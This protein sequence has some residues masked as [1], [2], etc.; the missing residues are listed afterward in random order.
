MKLL[1]AIASL[2]LFIVSCKKD[3][4]GCTD[5]NA[6]NHNPDA[7]INDGSCLYKGPATEEEEPLEPEPTYSCEDNT[8]ICRWH[9]DS[10]YYAHIVSDYKVEDRWFYPS[11]YMRLHADSSYIM[12]VGNALTLSGTFSFINSWS[13]VGILNLSECHLVDTLGFNG[14]LVLVDE[15]T[16]PNMRIMS[17][18]ECPNP[19][20]QGN[21]ERCYTGWIYHY[22]FSRQ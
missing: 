13:E 14:G 9:I 10:V 11:G 2:S 20:L 16:S 6:L 7:N 5:I 4:P 22:Y 3:V 12:K 8:M 15:I 1:I 21:G 18:G 19:Q 17:Y